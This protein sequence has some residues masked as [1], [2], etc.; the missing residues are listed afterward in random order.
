MSATRR[1]FLQATAAFLATPAL[2]GCLGEACAEPHP[3]AALSEW[4]DVRAQFDLTPDYIHM[5]SLLLASA[6]R[7]VQRA[8]ERYRRALDENPA[9]Y[10]ER[11]RWNLELRA[12]RV[13]AAYLGANRDDLALTHSTTEG[14]GLVYNGLRVRRDQEMVTTNHDYP[15]TRRALAL[16]SARCGA[17]LIR[18]PL[19]IDPAALDVDPLVDRLLGAVT[20]RTRVLALTW[21]HSKTGLK[22]PIARLAA[23]V[24][25]INAN[26]APAERLL[27]CVDGVHGLGVENFSVSDL[28]CDF[29]MAGTHKW[30]FGPRGTGILWGAPGTQRQLDE[31][32]PTFTPDGTFG[33]RLTPGGFKAFEHCWALPEAFLFHETIGKQRVTARI[34]GLN[35]QLKQELSTLPRVR[36]RTPLAA[37][38]SSGIT[39]FDVAGMA[40]ETVVERL[41]A[42]RIIASVT[43]YRDRSARLT[44][45][46]LNTP[47]EVARAVDAIRRL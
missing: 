26:R 7:R 30:L 39:C 6:P 43:P 5:A 45:G 47:D 14:I 10:A 41:Q 3:E 17:R 9:L 32:I 16:K 20:Q 34:R 21:V 13:A 22:F 1:E 40:P 31:T 28:G 15:A 33:G 8:I 27:L 29:F 11:N 12:R 44:P 18:V 36:L 2:A 37:S 46:I 4:G 38:L 35:E 42:E 25:E 19:A 23:K 24:S